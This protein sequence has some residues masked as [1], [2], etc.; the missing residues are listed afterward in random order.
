M[1]INLCN[2]ILTTFLQPIGNF[3]FQK[4]AQKKSRIYYIILVIILTF[5]F[6]IYIK[7]SSINITN[8]TISNHHLNINVYDEYTLK[9]NVFY[10]NNTIDNNVT[11]ASSNETIATVNNNGTIIALSSGTTIITAQATKNN[12]TKFVTC[13]ITVKSP[14]RG[15]FIRVIQGNVDSEVFIWIKP[16]DCNY[17]KINIYCISPSGN[18]LV[19]EQTFKPIYLDTECGLWT[20]YASIENDDGTYIGNKSSEIET[21]NV[22]N[23]PNT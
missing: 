2:I 1:Y 22:K 23:L 20:I 3:I 17:T 10:S 13:R 14:P 11:W 5:S 19:F 16:Y 21:I 9:A 6:I 8:M 7:T 15:Y 18:T 4:T 12:N